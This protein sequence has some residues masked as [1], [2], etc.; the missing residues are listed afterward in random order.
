MPYQTDERLKSYLDTNQLHREQMCRALLSIDKRFTDVRPRHPHGGPDGGRDIEA[1]FRQEQRAYGAIG[2]VN[3][4]NDSDE[5]KKSIKGKFKSD[6]E[7]TLNADPKPA[8]FVFLTN[9]NLTIGE[10]EALVQHAKAAGLVYCEIIDRERLRIS[11]DSPDGF[12]IRFQ[13]LGLPLSEEEQAS[14]FA[15]WGDDI[16]SVISTGFQRLEKTL[17]RVLFLQEASDV[18]TSLTLAF[19]LDRTYTAEEIG[20]FRAFCSMYLKE[21]KHKIFSILFGSSDKSNRMRSDSEADFTIQKSGI[22]YGIGGGQWEKYINLEAVDEG[23]ND[24]DDDDEKLKYT[25]VGS[26]SSIG[27]DSVE[28]ITIWYN[29]D[30]FIRYFPRLSLRDIDDAMF[31]PIVNKSLAEKVKAIHIY[32]NGYKLQEIT[33]SEFSIDTTSFDTEIPANFTDDEVSDVWV[34]I[35]PINA[36]AFRMSFSDQTPKRMFISRQTPNSL[37]SRNHGRTD[38]E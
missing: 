31:L 21:P 7:S 36:S 9:I 23:S 17:D 20:H 6:L 1:T 8:V 32:S 33:K 30:S 27:M 15:K 22:K 28:F 4:A 37:A 2:F 38:K 26:S 25:S 10:K 18:M 34:R 3:Q 35:R 12:S 13:Y 5:Q 14:F 16:Q 19:E 29:H 24:V 11:L